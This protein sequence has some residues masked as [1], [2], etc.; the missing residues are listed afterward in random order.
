MDDDN[1][2]DNDDNIANDND[3]DYDNNIVDDDNDNVYFSIAPNPKHVGGQ[4][5]K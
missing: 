3:E 5:C 1:D 4:H 2:E